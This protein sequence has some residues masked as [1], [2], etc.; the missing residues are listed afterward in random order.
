MDRAMMLVASGYGDRLTKRKKL[1][2]IER[3]RRDVLMKAPCVVI[4]YLNEV[5]QPGY[6][7]IPGL[8]DQMDAASCRRALRIARELAL[9]DC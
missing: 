4:R 9:S 5:Y 6:Q 3:L 8:V 1:T 7:D 2:E